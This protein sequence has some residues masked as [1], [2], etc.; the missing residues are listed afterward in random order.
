MFTAAGSGA[1]SAALAN[2]SYRPVSGGRCLREAGG[3]ATLSGW[4]GLGVGAWS[5]YLSPR[6]GW[7]SRSWR[8]QSSQERRQ[9]L[10]CAGFQP[11]PETKSWEWEV[12]L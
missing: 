3:V 2:T 7:T 4:A 8:L 10:D 1:D 11:R 12:L 6:L 5:V 9:T